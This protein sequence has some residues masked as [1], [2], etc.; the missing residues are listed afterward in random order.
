M[1]SSGATGLDPG[2][3]R[4]ETRLKLQFPNSKLQRNLKS[5]AP[6]FKLLRA[7]QSAGQGGK[8][9]RLSERELKFSRRHGF[10]A[11]KVAS[12]FLMLTGS[13]LAWE[14]VQLKPYPQKVRTFYRLPDPAVPAALLSNSVPLPVSD[15]TAMVRASDRAFWL[16]TT[17]GLMRLDFSAPERDRRQYLAGRRYLPDDH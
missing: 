10:R 5:Q 1:N 11:W 7:G 3:T 12:L 17:Q 15:I 6:N 4:R 13:L 8:A 16:G 14:P 2:L 9:A